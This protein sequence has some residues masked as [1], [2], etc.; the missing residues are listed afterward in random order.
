MPKIAFIGQALTVEA[1]LTGRRQHVYHAVMLESHTAAELDLDQIT[2]LAG[3]LVSAHG[4]WPPP[5]T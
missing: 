1:I 3:E 4:S 5:L 2:N